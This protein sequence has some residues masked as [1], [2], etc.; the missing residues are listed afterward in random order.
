MKFFNCK[1]KISLDFVVSTHLYD[2]SVV[3]NI[4]KTCLPNGKQFRSRVVTEL[5]IHE[6]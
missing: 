3:G 6:G 4:L 1:K 5:L 2:Y